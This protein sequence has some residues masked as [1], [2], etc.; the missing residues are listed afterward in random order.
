M[1]TEC[2]LVKDLLPLYSENMVSD[3]T[4]AL[5]AE[6]LNECADCAAEAERLRQPAAEIPASK[7]PT[8]EAAPLKRVKKELIRRRI[9]AAVL[10][11]AIVFVAAFSAFSFVTR[12]NYVPFEKSGAEVHVS[13]NGVMS[14][15]FSERVT[16]YRFNGYKDAE[17]GAF[18]VEIVAW[19]S[20]WDK[21]LG[22]EARD[23]LLTDRSGISPDRVFYMDATRQDD[24][25]L[26]IYGEAP[27]G[28][29]TALP[30]LFLGAYFLIALA[31]AAVLGILLFVF[32]KKIKAA[33]ILT[34]ALFAPLSYLAAHLVLLQGFVSY[35][36]ARDFTMLCIAAVGVYA[37]LA[38]GRMRK[39]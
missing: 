14:V 10:A 26:T 15:S 29:A 9:A 31:L 34:F 27:Q 16:S 28:G 11:A 18:V 17:D 20:V 13:E 19:N 25:L 33:R 30:R 1:K 8:D 12:P 22:K 2:C 21:I 4:A 39:F 7:T 5:V 3:E 24:N 6:H 38:A 36:A 37:A 35:S 23:L 32:R